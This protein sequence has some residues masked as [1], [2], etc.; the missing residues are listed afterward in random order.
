MNYCTCNI[1]LNYIVNIVADH[2]LA[3]VP[4]QPSTFNV[5]AVFVVVLTLCGDP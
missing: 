5:L 1:R 3:S 4:D 2:K